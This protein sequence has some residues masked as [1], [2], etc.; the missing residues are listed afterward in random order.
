MMSLLTSR[1]ARARAH[2]C[3]FLAL[4]MVAVLVVSWTGFLAPCSADKEAESKPAKID[5]EAYNEKIQAVVKSKWHPEADYKISK[6]AVTMLKFQINKDGR[7]VHVS[8]GKPSGIKA[9]DQQAQITLMQCKFDPLPAGAPELVDVEFAFDYKVP[10]KNAAAE[11]TQVATGGE[12]S[13]ND[14]KPL[15][16]EKDWFRVFHYLMRFFA[17]V[18]VGFLLFV[19]SIMI[20]VFLLW[21][22]I[23]SLKL[24]FRRRWAAGK[25][26]GEQAHEHEC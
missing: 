10:Q 18:V 4:Q 24:F 23:E 25:T 20:F 13:S 9:I 19:Q 26:P 15:W 6:D 22:G 21:L 7:P 11:S 3:K 8:I 17:P 16:G 2:H 12:T 5:W 14:S 1:L